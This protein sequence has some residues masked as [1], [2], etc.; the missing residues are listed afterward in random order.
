[1]AGDYDE[2]ATD[3]TGQNATAPTD[4]DSADGD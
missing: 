3:A 1:M 2:N 4:Q